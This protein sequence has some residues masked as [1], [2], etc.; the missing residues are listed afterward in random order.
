MVSSMN[1][2][3]DS[4]R[5]MQVLAACFIL[6]SMVLPL[7]AFPEGKAASGIEGAIGVPYGNPD[8]L[9][10]GPGSVAPGYSSPV[11]TFPESSAGSGSSLPATS[12]GHGTSRSLLAEKVT[13]YGGQ[14]ATGFSGKGLLIDKLAGRSSV[15]SNPVGGNSRVVS[16]EGT[17]R[18]IDLDGGFYGI[19][20]TTGEQYRPDNLPAAMKHEG[21]RIR[22]EGVV[23]DSAPDTLTWGR[24]LSLTGI[25]L[26]GGQISSSGTV[27]YIELE[28]G[29]FGI[30]T[31]D[32]RK[33]LPLNLPKEFQVDGM[34]VTFTAREKTDLATIFMWGTP[35]NLESIDSLGRLSLPLEGSWS[36]MTY[37]GRS[38]NPGT[39]ITAEFGP[40]GKV[41]GTTGCNQY[42]AR[43]TATGSG[44]R[45]G[46][47][48]STKMYCS[49]PKGIMEQEQ[50]FLA[51]LARA[52]SW[53]MNNGNLV[54]Q[55]AQEREILVFSSAITDKPAL[56]IEYSRMGGIAGEDDILVLF[57]NG[58]GTVTRRGISQSVKVPQP[59][60]ADLISHITAADFPTLKEHYPAPIE[61]ADY[62]TYTLT[63][64]GRTV[65][66][67]DT[68]VPPIL[69]PIINILNDIISS[70]RMTVEPGRSRIPN[71]F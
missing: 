34:P 56:I 69:V 10:E 44:L 61:G 58:S 30:I 4:I 27:K 38:L 39:M 17:V 2:K 16:G 21:L 11:A 40:D 62:F 19:V 3:K 6:A 33:Y 29:F 45:I 71:F 47:V 68:G 49:S 25:S 64:G 60:M 20:T 22:F 43:Y 8:P 1:M 52:A 26:S 51:L 41:A 48:G 7:A 63:A 50:E 53:T 36:L 67:E 46:T 9:T 12:E 57:T 13:G 59:V 31:P 24:T 14:T 54:I 28:G 23:R 35:L 70:A 37:N 15:P 42:V 65:V 66:T 5:L 18:F 55:D 32:G